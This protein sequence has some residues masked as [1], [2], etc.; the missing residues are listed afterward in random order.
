MRV[1]IT[2]LAGFIGFHI[3]SALHQEGVKVLGLDNFNAYYDPSWKIKRALLLKSQGIETLEMDLCDPSFKDAIEAFQPTHL[4]H[5]AAQAGVRYS[6]IN[7]KA[8]VRSNLEGFTHVLEA[9]RAFPKIH[10]V[11]ASSSSVYGLNARLPYSV[12][13]RTDQQASFYGV[14]KRANELMAATYSHLFGIRAT[15]LRYF[16]VYGPWGRPDM[17]LFSFTE[18]ILSGKP[19]DLY[20][21]GEMQRDFTYIDDIAAGTIAALK[22]Q[23][24]TPIFNLG[25]NSPVSLLRFVEILEKAL[26]KKAVRRLLPMQPG[27]IAATFADI[28]ESQ[29][30]LGFQPRTSLE[31]GIGRFVKWY[32]EEKGKL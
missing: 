10:L 32:L 29:E 28:K 6:L 9:V 26:D 11:F 3:A 2:G 5:L 1:F 21:Y 16:T 24:T 12:Q 7:P 27:D 8:Y 25:N 13:D 20:N 22:Y 19:I 18:A 15:A 30:E 17:A 23:G 31:E 14:T 4:L